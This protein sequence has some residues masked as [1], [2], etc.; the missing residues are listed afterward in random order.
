MSNS[1]WQ[2]VELFAGLI[3]K[4]SFYHRGH[5]L[6]VVTTTEHASCRF[7]FYLIDSWPIFIMNSFVCKL[8]AV[9]RPSLF[10]RKPAQF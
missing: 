6:Q 3:L 5:K 10:Y 7:G 2:S 4:R 9:E 8:H 1:R